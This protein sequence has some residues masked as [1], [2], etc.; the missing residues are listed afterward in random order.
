MPKEPITN[1]VFNAVLLRLR[2]IKAGENYFC[3]PVVHDQKINVERHMC[4]A[5]VVY[6]AGEEWA[7]NG[8]GNTET[9][10]CGNVQMSVAQQI[11]I[12]LFHTAPELINRLK[13]DVEIALRVNDLKA[14]NLLLPVG[15]QSGVAYSLQ[16]PASAS[17][18]EGLELEDARFTLTAIYSRAHGS[19]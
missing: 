8:G 14:G 18:G 2:A 1:A 19:P 11:I 9:G 13:A 16:G 12:C 5:I 15:E 17:P 7:V 10:A 6:Q 4:P 3:S